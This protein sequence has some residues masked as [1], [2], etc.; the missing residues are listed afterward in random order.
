MKR[1]LLSL[2]AALLAWQALAIPA[3][4][5]AFPY[6]QPD[7]SIIMLEL[8][9]DE[10]ISWT[11]LAGTTQVVSL[12]KDGF[13]HP[14]VIKESQWAAARKRRVQA[15]EGRQIGLR[16]HNDNKMTH[17]TRHIPVLLV[18]FQDQRFVL[19]NPQER[20]NAMLNQAGYSE[21]G[22]TGSVQDYYLENSK[23]QFQPV[24]DVY[25]PVLLPND[26]AYYGKPVRDDDGDVTEHDQHAEL[27]LYHAAL[28]L[29]ESIDFSQYDYDQDGKVDMTL[30]YYAGYNE[31]EHAHENTIWPHQWNLMAS[32]DADAKK[33]KFDGVRLAKYFCSSE[34]RGKS[35]ADM[36]G[37]GTTCHEF[38]HSLGLPD[39]YDT[40]YEKNGSCSAVYYFSI[41]ASGNDLNKS[42]TPPYFNA[43][44]RIYLGWLL[45][46]DVQELPAGALSFGS[47][48]DDIVYKTP[49]ATEGEY[50]L[51]ECRDGSGWDAYLPKGLLVYHAD[52]STVRDVGG[53]TPAY[54]WKNWNTNN[55]ISAFGDHPC[56]YVVP[57]SDQSNLLYKGELD[58][59]VFPGSSQV[60]S[61]EPVDWEG[62]AVGVSLTGISFADGKVSLTARYTSEK[63]VEGCVTD[64]DNI[65]LEGVYLLL[66]PLSDDKTE[67][68]GVYDALSDKDGNFSIGLGELDAPYARI[69]L[70]KEGYQTLSEEIVL[71]RRLVIAD[72]ELEPASHE[73]TID[74]FAQLGIPAIADPGQ[75]SYTAG[76]VFQLEMEMPEGFYP[77]VSWKFD[78][79]PVTDP[80][81]L[82]A[83]IHV[84]SAI[85]VHTDGSTETLELQIDV[86]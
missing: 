85:L 67:L 26:M 56:F 62:I 21:G 61:Y 84:I 28:A 77:A 47:I 15:E 24:F 1:F 83:G 25:G 70:S 48:K 41:M 40:D 73:E 13:W 86:K 55:R 7:G 50:F 59:W 79:R 42:R 82:Q 72:F 64:P 30:F 3:K 80:V 17:G 71:D 38:G 66:T 14:S 20:F 54:Y 12:G 44:E 63:T 27:A 37:I 45:E 78:G 18:E 46:S 36:C 69:T 60:N 75:G 35:G 23:G 65:A 4:P 5:G 10:F 11:T 52:K 68:P 16:T 33:A 8:H 19:D 43:E 2:I 76:D 39:F 49:T 53:Q 9:G 22:A 57:S 74:S 58:T 6:T 51:Y 81:T 29:D 32:P 31:A 34:L